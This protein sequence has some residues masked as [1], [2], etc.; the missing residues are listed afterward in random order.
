MDRS[1]RLLPAATCVVA[2][3]AAATA[4]VGC[5]HRVTPRAARSAALVQSAQTFAEA[6]R[7]Q[8]FQ[9]CGGYLAPEVREEFQARIAAAEGALEITDSELV[10]V[11]WAEDDVAA[12]VRVRMRW[13]ELPS[14]VER[15]ATVEQRWEERKEGWL[16]SRMEVPGG[17]GQ[18]VLDIL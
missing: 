14:L 16:L 13:L 11:Q 12:T 2:V 8:R 5:A 6:L 1:R 18:T 7:W 17:D 9:R 15:R 10:D 4:A 3:I